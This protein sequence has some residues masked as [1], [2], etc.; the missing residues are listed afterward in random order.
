MFQNV[1]WHK[2]SLLQLRSHVASN[3]HLLPIDLNELF[4]T[5]NFNYFFRW[6]MDDLLGFLKTKMYEPALLKS[7]V[8]LIGMN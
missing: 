2:I 8:Q 1:A 6:D 7:Q 4:D 5:C 3:I